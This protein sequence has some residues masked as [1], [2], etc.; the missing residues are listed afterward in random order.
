MDFET[1]WQLNS[2]KTWTQED[3]DEFMDSVTHGVQRAK[4]ANTMDNLVTLC[5]EHHVKAENGIVEV[6]N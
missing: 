3:I 1:L 4:E 6:S 5:Q 2:D